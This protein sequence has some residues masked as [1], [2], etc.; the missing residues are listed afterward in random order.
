[1]TDKK[2]QRSDAVGGAVC[3]ASQTSRK[4]AYRLGITIFCVAVFVALIA[5][6]GCTPQAN[7]GGSSAGGS[8]DDFIK[9]YEADHGPGDPN[10]LVTFH[11]GQKNECLDCHETPDTTDMG[12]EATCLASCH[13]REK[14][15][16]ATNDYGGLHARGI[17]TSF[18]GLDQGLNPHRSHMEDMQCG[19]C[20]QMHGTSVMQCNE[21]HYLP[22]PT[23]W[24]DVFD[25]E[26]S[27]GL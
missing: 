1:M 9:T 8:M 7:S 16:A 21:C 27:P 26:G 6:A 12:S 15:I 20:H 10:Q 2:T 18:R 4:K 19:D 25:G 13:T 3:T 24:T 11:Y 23:G 22:L 14:I 17:S 5:I